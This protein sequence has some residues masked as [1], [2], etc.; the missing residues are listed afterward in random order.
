MNRMRAGNEVDLSCCQNYVTCLKVSTKAKPLIATEKEEKEKE[1]F[2]LF[3]KKVAY[4]R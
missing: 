3:F 4:A 2:S 1:L